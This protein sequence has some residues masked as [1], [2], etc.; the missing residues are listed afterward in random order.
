MNAA[1][2]SLGL[3]VLCCALTREQLTFVEIFVQEFHLGAS[4]GRLSRFP[5]TPPDD[6]EVTLRSVR[7]H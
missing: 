6:A 1:R 3:R 4:L 5:A 2:S 7:Q